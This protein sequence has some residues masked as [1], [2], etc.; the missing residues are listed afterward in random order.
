M[1]RFFSRAVVASLLFIGSLTQPMAG[2]AR[3]VLARAGAPDTHP[4]LHITRRELVA[5]GHVFGSAGSYEKIVGT[6]DFQLDPADPRNAAITDLDKAP[7]NAAGRVQ[8][9]TDVYVLHP[10]DPSGWNHRVVYEVNNRGRKTM[11]GPYDF[12]IANNDPTALEDFG[13]ALLLN[14]GYAL[15]WA[16]WQGDLLPAPNLMTVRVSLATEA[17]GSPIQQ[18]I[19]VE[20]T[21]DLS[22]PPDG[23]ATCV[24]LSGAAPYYAYPPVP[25][26]MANAQ[27]WVRDSDSSEPPAADIP[28][29]ALVPQDQWSF[30][31]PTQLCL[32]SGFQGGKVYE[33][34]YVATNPLVL[35]VGYAATRDVLSFFRYASADE[36]GTPNPLDI[37]GGVQH[38]LGYGSSQSGAYVRDFIYQGF[39]EDLAGR[40]VMD[41]VHVHIGAAFLGQGE[42]YRFGQLNPWSDQHRGRIYP[43]V[44]FP[45]NWGVRENPLVVNG[46]T[47][48]PREDGILKRPE[49]DPLVVQTNS[50]NE[51]RWGGAGLVA[52]DGFGHDVALPDNVR[53]Y[54]LAGTQH[55]AGV[56]ATPT[57]GIC[58]QPNNPTNQ[59][60]AMRALFTALDQWVAE[61]AEPPP[62]RYPTV[63]AG[64]LVSPEPASMGFP[65]IPGVK[66][67]GVYNAMGEKDYGPGVSGNR[68]VIT[69]W[70]PAFVAT[71]KV[72]VPRSDALG[73]DLGGLRVPNAGVPIAT[74][75]G[76]NLRRAPYTE[77]DLCGLSGMF[78]PL[79]ETDS[80]AVSSGD[81]RPSL[82]TLYGTH[83]GYVQAMTDYVNE[84]VQDRYLLPE[85]AAQAI[86]DAAAS[87][88][89][90]TGSG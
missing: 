24:A 10:I 35:G 20:Y 49:T 21:D 1:L 30:A 11:L 19:A 56:G 33:L 9:S 59:A 60:P 45:F 85:D 39:N 28:K 46:T 89:L 75:T 68:G 63:A 31:S 36:Q 53:Y 82:E 29:G 13:D 62:S 4:S 79:P 34:D 25:A 44:T 71:Y 65:A 2:Q 43:S 87:D 37:D 57:M 50:S 55:A 32:P 8:Y 51:F 26:E 42:N 27:L 54:V 12:A 86:Q 88:V 64:T 83:A 5:E 47:R 38:V 84:L 80:K 6:I 15:V 16:G 7:R 40:R 61:R 48:G 3:P 22:F 52:T 76:W 81:P 78:L 67:A 66:Y 74:L 73:M 23:S 17:D 58:Q 18:R 41:G 90:N 77:G 70:H 72:L 69:N 14:R